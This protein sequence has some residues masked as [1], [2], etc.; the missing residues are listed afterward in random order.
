MITWGRVYWPYFLLV[1]SL[2]F[3]IP[4]LIAFFTN[5]ANTLSEYSWDELHVG[6][7]QVHTIS[8]YLSLGTWVLFVVL[9]TLHIWWRTF[10]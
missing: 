3:L 10:G 5:K 1:V 8:W 6:A 4:E 9:I 2:T 7:L